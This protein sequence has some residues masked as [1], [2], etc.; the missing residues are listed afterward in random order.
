MAAAVLRKPDQTTARQP[1]FAAP[2]PTRPPISA[3][4]LLDGMPSS[5]VT[6]FQ[7]IAPQRAA[8]M[9]P[10]VTISG[11]MMPLPTVWATLRPKT[12]K[13]T[14]LKNAAQNTASE[15]RNTRVETIVAMELAASCR[16]LRKSKKSAVAI[17]PISRGVA[18]AAFIS[19]AQR[20]SMTM[21]LTWFATPSKRS[22][23]FS[24]CS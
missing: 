15:G 1:A 11:S 18:R 17:R 12:K 19:G 23:T 20:C 16:P 10:A 14:K 22:R 6:T 3:C 21:E 2:A 24:R 8:K 9:T 7:T 13:A 5:Q 4:E